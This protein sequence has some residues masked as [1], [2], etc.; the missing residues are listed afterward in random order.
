[1]AELDI[2]E[3]T[4][5]KDY[6]YVDQDYSLTFTHNINDRLFYTL[7]GQYRIT[8]DIDKLLGGADGEISGGVF[9]QRYKN[10]TKTFNA[11]VGYDLSA[12]SE[13]ELS[14]GFTQF[15]SLTTDSSDMY[16]AYARYAYSLSAQTELQII[17][18]YFYYDFG[19]N[20]QFDSD[21]DGF[22]DDFSGG[23]ELSNYSAGAGVQHTF[24]NQA[25]LAISLGYRYTTA[26]TS[27]KGIDK[28][29]VPYKN[30]D[31]GNN[32][33]WVATFRLKKDVADFSW[34]LQASHDLKVDTQGNTSESTRFYV[35]TTYDITRRLFAGVNMHVQR[36]YL[37]P[38][39]SSID[40]GG[41]K[42]DDWTYRLDN[43]LNYDF[44]RWLDVVFGY[45]YRYTDYKESNQTRHSNMF[46]LNLT[47]TPLRPLVV[48]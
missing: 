1:M 27:V 24:L 15:D 44:N 48:Y 3:Y 9:Y 21:G 36:S 18:S 6:N 33:G 29:G 41:R 16:H 42:K 12:R 32:D 11:V 4:S 17:T 10:K 2:A 45:V 22:L 35:E 13:L 37:D 30:S 5:E 25:E 34:M 28:N 46:Y 38:E 23:Y 39:D 14:G 43:S 7:S 8:N 26:D 19:Y 47:F 40:R 31:S 20:D